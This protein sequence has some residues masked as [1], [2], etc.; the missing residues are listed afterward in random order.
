MA[1]AFPNNNELIELCP[2]NWSLPE[3]RQYLSG[4]RSKIVELDSIVEANPRYHDP[5]RLAVALEKAAL[6]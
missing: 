4:S 5:H 1:R 6:N 3:R 2:M